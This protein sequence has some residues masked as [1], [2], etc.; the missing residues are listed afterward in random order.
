MT[1][2]YKFEGRTYNTTHQAYDACYCGPGAYHSGLGVGETY[3]TYWAAGATRD[4]GAEGLLYWVF[5]RP[6]LSEDEEDL[7]ENWEW[8]DE[9]NFHKFELEVCAYDLAIE[10]GKAS[11]C[12]VPGI[13]KP[14]PLAEQIAVIIAPPTGLVD[15]ESLTIM[16]EAVAVTRDENWVEGSTIWSFNDGSTLKWSGSE[17]E[18][19]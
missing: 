7:C 1:D 19:Y 16:A 13:H 2:S 6:V 10:E 4:D 15:W 5:S 9:A 3:L 12:L 17:L 14:I 18:T 11:P 8:E